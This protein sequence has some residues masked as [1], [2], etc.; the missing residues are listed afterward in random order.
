[1]LV[2]ETLTL[3][4]APLIPVRLFTPLLML[5]EVAPLVT[6]VKVAEPPAAMLDGET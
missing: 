3:P 4:E 2:G 1:M 6:Q 5:T